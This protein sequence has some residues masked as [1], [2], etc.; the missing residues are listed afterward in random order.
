MCPASGR[1]GFH[2]KALE[3]ALCVIVE[4]T[5]LYNV[6]CLDGEEVHSYRRLCLDGR[7]VFG[8]G[9]LVSGGYHSLQLIK[10]SSPLDTR[11]LITEVLGGKNYQFLLEFTQ[12]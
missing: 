6:T 10:S 12:W 11:E 7:S 5:F 8:P 3:A 9:A 1:F 4:T 2:M